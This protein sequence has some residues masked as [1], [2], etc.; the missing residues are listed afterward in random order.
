MRCQ[1]VLRTLRYRMVSRSRESLAA[2]PEKRPT[3]AKSSCLIRCSASTVDCP[4]AL[5]SAACCAADARCTVAWTESR[6]SL[7]YCSAFSCLSSSRLPCDQRI[8]PSY[9]SLRMRFHL[10]FS[11]LLSFLPTDA[12]FQLTV[13]GQPTSASM[14]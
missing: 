3:S 2:A 8:Y 12:T 11:L 6:S 14:Y 9:T 10:V 1:K 5:G 13:E 7:H 4:P